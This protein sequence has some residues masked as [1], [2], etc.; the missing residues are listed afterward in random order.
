MS[1]GPT[2]IS[3][4]ILAQSRSRG[5]ALVPYITAGFPTLDAFIPTLSA[6]APHAACIEI[7]VPFTDPMA[8]GATIQRSSHAALTNG[9]SLA[10]ILDQLRTHWSPSAQAKQTPVLLMSYLNPLLSL[11][12]AG[13]AS[14]ASGAGVSAMI[15]PDL[16]LEECEPIKRAL[17]A[18]SVGLVQMVTPVT[19]DERLAQLA[20]ASDGFLYAVTMTGVTG[21]ASSGMNVDVGDYLL[22]LRKLSPVPVCAGFGIRSRAN[23][24]ALSALCDGAIVGSA[25]VEV[26]EKR[27]DPAKFLA[28]L[29]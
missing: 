17:N 4:A 23:V 26:L 13:L 27:E 25:L 28:S 19:P 22:K 21:G 7:G 9:A 20:R 16:P 29:L 24:Q 12:L 1:S 14:A 10:W 11:G 2:R 3:D 15:I 6:I 5:I 8:D 18:A